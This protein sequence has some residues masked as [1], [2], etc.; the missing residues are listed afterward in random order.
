MPTERFYRLPREKAE[1]IRMAAIREFK[2]VPPEEVSINK[3]IR[4]AEISRG[5]FYTYFADKTELLSWLMRDVVKGHKRFYVQTLLQN[6]GDIW[7]VFDKALDSSIELVSEKKLVEIAVN[8]IQSRYF[9]D[10]FRQ[11]LDT[12]PVQYGTGDPFYHWLYVHC[13][14]ERCPADAEDFEIMM[15]FQLMALVSALK[16]YFQGRF[17]RETLERFYKKRIEF[18][19][20]GVFGGACR[21]DSESQVGRHS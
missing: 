14:R 1:A 19:R 5:S 4:D 7:D 20:C 15:D 6:G 18:I 9:S 21:T 11:H 12:D 17:P 13:D 10:Y 3:I 16:L 2:R 8:L